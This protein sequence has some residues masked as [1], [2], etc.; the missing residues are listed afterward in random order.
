MFMETFIPGIYC[1]CLGMHLYKEKKKQVLGQQHIDVIQIT[2]MFNCLNL[3]IYIVNYFIHTF[4]LINNLHEDI[5]LA[6]PLNYS[7]LLIKS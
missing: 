4:S 5:I 6:L 3:Q 7:P 2:L 1:Q